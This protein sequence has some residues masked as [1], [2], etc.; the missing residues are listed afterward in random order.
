[1]SYF[2]HT[3]L[4]SATEPQP[5]NAEEK[6]PLA[7]VDL[8]LIRVARLRKICLRLPYVTI[9]TTGKHEAF[10]VD[11][12]TFA[13]YLSDYR[14]DGISGVCCR[15]RSGNT[16]RPTLSAHS[17]WFTP[18]SVALKGWVGL[19]LDQPAVD[20]GEVSDLVRGT[21]LRVAPDSNL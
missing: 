5:S 9:A 16:P 2:A 6:T 12:R 20:W 13:C 18:T 17:P 4:H 11:G 10:L 7:M 8:R 21:Y 19:R 15:P 14:G 3:T 1:M